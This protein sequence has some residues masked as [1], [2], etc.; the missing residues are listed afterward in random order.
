MNSRPSK[1]DPLFGLNSNQIKFAFG[2][3]EKQSERDYAK[4]I[5]THAIVKNE[6]I[7][8][9]I[10]NLCE[11]HQFKLAE[12]EL[13]EQTLFLTNL[14]TI[15]NN[16][17][18]A[19]VAEIVIELCR[20]DVAVLSSHIQQLVELL[21]KHSQSGLNF[22]ADAF[23][24]LKKHKSSISPTEYAKLLHHYIRQFS[25]LD[26]SEIERD[27]FHIAIESKEAFTIL[28]S[29]LAGSFPAK[30]EVACNTVLEA[31]KLKKSINEAKDDD[32]SAV[33]LQAIILKKMNADLEIIGT[34][35]FLLELYYKTFKKIKFE[36]TENFTL[37]PV[38]VKAELSASVANSLA[39]AI[40][41][42]AVIA[43]RRAE[44]MNEYVPL[45][46]DST[47]EDVVEI[48]EPDVEIVQFPDVV[49]KLSASSYL[50]PEVQ[51]RI[52]ATAINFTDSF[53]NYAAAKQAILSN[54]T[55]HLD[56]AILMTAFL[57]E[58]ENDTSSTFK[59]ILN[60]AHEA[61]INDSTAAIVLFNDLVARKANG[62]GRKDSRLFSHDE[63]TAITLKHAENPAFVTM[64]Q[65][66][67]QPFIIDG[68]EAD[69]FTNPSLT[70]LLPA[71]SRFNDRKLAAV[72][73]IIAT[74]DTE[75]SVAIR[76]NIVKQLLNKPLTFI[77][78]TQATYLANFLLEQQTNP[79]F[80]SSLVDSNDIVKNNLL[81]IAESDVELGRE[82]INSKYILASS[83]VTPA[84][85]QFIKQA[86]RV[87]S[88]VDG[89][90]REGMLSKLSHKDIEFATPHEVFACFMKY[91]TDNEFVAA[92]KSS[93][94]LMALL[95]RSA[96]NSKSDAAQLLR[97]GFVKNAENRPA[98]IFNDFTFDLIDQI[99]PSIQCALLKHLATEAMTNE[100]LAKKLLAIK[101]LDNFIGSEL[102]IKL[103]NN[104]Y[105]LVTSNRGDIE[106]R[107]YKLSRHQSSLPA[108][109]AYLDI[110]YYLK[111]NPIPLVFQ[112]SSLDRT[113]DIL[114]SYP[115]QEKT[116]LVAKLMLHI[117]S[118]LLSAEQLATLA[119]TYLDQFKGDFN[120][121]KPDVLRAG[122]DSSAAA[123]T[124]VHS[125]YVVDNV[126][127]PQ[128][129][130]IDTYFTR[131]QITEMM[132][133]H[134]ICGVVEDIRFKEQEI[135]NQVIAA[136][137]TYRDII[138]IIHHSDTK[139][140]RES[141]LSQ[142]EEQKT[143]IKRK[144]GEISDSLIHTLA[145]KS[146]M[147]TQVGNSLPT[148]ESITKLLDEE[149]ST[150]LKKSEADN[151]R[152]EK[153]KNIHNAHERGVKLRT[154][155]DI[156]KLYTT[157]QINIL[158]DEALVS[159]HELERHQ[160]QREVI[161]AFYNGFFKD[162]PL[163]DGEV[164]EYADIG[165]H[166][167]LYIANLYKELLDSVVDNRKKNRKFVD[168]QATCISSI[169]QANERLQAKIT[170]TLEQCNNSIS[171]LFAEV[172]DNPETIKSAWEL[173]QNQNNDAAVQIHLES[174]NKASLISHYQ[175]E[176]TEKHRI[177][178][179]QLELIEVANR[180]ANGLNHLIENLT[181]NSELAKVCKEVG[182]LIDQLSNFEQLKI[183]N[184]ICQ[185]DNDFESGYDLKKSILRIIAKNRD[186]IRAAHSS[187][188]AIRENINKISIDSDVAA[189]K[190]SILVE[191]CGIDLTNPI[192]KRIL[193]NELN[194]LST[195]ANFLIGGLTT[196]HTQL[197]DIVDLKHHKAIYD[198]VSEKFQLLKASMDFIMNHL[199]SIEFIIRSKGN[200]K[201]L[202]SFIMKTVNINKR[203]SDVEV[204]ERPISVN[205]FQAMKQNMIE[206]MATYADFVS[207]PFA[208]G[209]GKH[210]HSFES[211]DS[212]KKAELSA[213]VLKAIN[214]YTAEKAPLFSRSKF[215]RIR[216]NEI[217]AIK[218]IIK[219]S[220][221]SQSFDEFK[222]S[223]EAIKSR[224]TPGFY[225]SRLQTYIHDALESK[226]I[227]NKPAYIPQ[228]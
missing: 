83:T 196:I 89:D 98:L 139:L 50:S 68:I 22:S 103:I 214:D 143:M 67:P 52:F 87:K 5:V 23:N 63:M 152:S 10:R 113:F 156:I 94:S 70:L 193:S 221:S 110:V 207:E 11:I 179:E 105:D 218:K 190:Q 201:Q 135:L 32:V 146:F 172:S 136:V 224:I 99:E 91:A 25:V 123:H 176:M 29:E 186:L 109:L 126:D 145:Y 149:L 27:V 31:D 66:F 191:L 9:G 102:F 140:I 225:Q 47:D 164:V 227:V 48:D 62:T 119:V 80:V 85:M 38:D 148:G 185:L 115:N 1:H 104:H 39:E 16:F 133:K 215:T 82:I 158:I 86:N 168:E 90:T 169:N 65:N 108:A 153:F 81:I 177:H 100:A 200:S 101:K 210:F 45:F 51:P 165:G 203:I 197:N 30:W 64:T 219:D 118:R 144:L 129:A 120:R 182:E 194:D 75:A 49:T 72:D 206:L 76:C 3:A 208:D 150:K 198:K 124:I 132:L 147:D 17:N 95:Y 188:N 183:V 6:A 97:T 77:N 212:L 24:L 106:D 189:I 96:A 134:R 170:T 112:P 13:A 154:K 69:S 217:N 33:E 142:A 19:K 60:I 175:A 26:L 162:K 34:E 125:S 171:N 151:V 42:E 4:S 12:F 174:Y 21:M 93:D 121:I 107:L 117:W 223:I 92:V 88:V 56:A 40:Q 2:K 7:A 111:R 173:T 20:S 78:R 222:A 74:I 128:A 202:K 220:P 228:V 211:E 8:N 57:N 216:L 199:D 79:E 131:D 41:E 204:M 46:P 138:A 226:A 192:Q 59:S 141:I 71:D 53:T 15:S 36:S 155:I 28:A 127:S 178:T 159:V 58:I 54:N 14:F 43:Q 73:A 184:T 213:K 84:N 161:H 122:M 180:V 37:S 35:S 181:V 44:Q 163:S 18:N 209:I 157:H 160:N 195:N 116:N 130:I 114:V 167:T 137:S 61:A 187:V 55:N 205:E 166:V